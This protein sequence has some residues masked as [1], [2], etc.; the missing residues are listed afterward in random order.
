MENNLH[1][2]NDKSYISANQVFSLT[3]PIQVCCFLLLTEQ[4]LDF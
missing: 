1:L 2:L 3:L 4:A